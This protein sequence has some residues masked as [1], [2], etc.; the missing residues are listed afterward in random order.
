MHFDGASWHPLLFK[1]AQKKPPKVFYLI[2]GEIG[3]IG[4]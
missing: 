1:A 2:T 3:N 4:L